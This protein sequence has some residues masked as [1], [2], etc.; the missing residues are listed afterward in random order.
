MTPNQAFLMNFQKND[1]EKVLLGDNGTRDVKGT[2]S[3]QIA[4]HDGM[5]RILTNVK[6]VPELKHN[7][8]SHGELNK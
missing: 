4:T 2:S 8:I 7:L 5:I 3:V 1:G 6:Y